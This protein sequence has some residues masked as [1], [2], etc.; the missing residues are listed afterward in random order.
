MMSAQAGPP[1]G[2]DPHIYRHAD[3]QGAVGNLAGMNEQV[4]KFLLRV[5]DGD[6]QT[7]GC[8]EAALI[9]L[10]SAGF[11]VKGRLVDDNRNLIAR[12]G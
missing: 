8:K 7:A 10:L 4:T 11:A 2:V 12:P 1:L 9:A 3:L 5:F 6:I